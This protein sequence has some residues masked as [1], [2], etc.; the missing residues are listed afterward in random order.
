MVWRNKMAGSGLAQLGRVDALLDREGQ[1][2]AAERL[3][4]G[5]QEQGHVV[6]LGRKLGTASRMYLSSHAR[7][8]RRW[9]HAV[10]LAL[11]LVD[12]DQAPVESR[13]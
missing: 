8:A 11:A 13:S 2:I 5:R 7:P 12:Q 4:L 9:A 3:A 6:R 1:M 10:L